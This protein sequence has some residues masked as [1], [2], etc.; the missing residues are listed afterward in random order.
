MDLNHLTTISDIA[1]TVRTTLGPKGMNKFVVGN[2]PIMTND[3]A[4]IIKHLKHPHPLF[5]PIKNLANSQEETVGDGTTTTMILLAE[6]LRGAKTLIEKGMHPVTVIEGYNLC[7]HALIQYLM[8][9]SEELDL[10][11]V[12]MTTFGSKI[13]PELAKH[14]APMIEPDMDIFNLKGDPLNSEVVSGFM[15][16]GHTINDQMPSKAAGKIAVLNLRTMIDGVKVQASTADELT[17]L[18]HKAHEDRLNVVQALQEYKVEVLVTNDSDET[19]NS[20]LAQAGIMTIWTGD[21]SKLVK[22]CKVTGAQIT[23]FPEERYLGECT[24]TYSKKPNFIR[25]TGQESEVK[26]LLLYG[27]TEQTL[28]ETKLAVEDVIG[29]IKSS[30]GQ[31]YGGGAIEMELS[32][33]LRANVNTVNGK[34]QIAVEKFAE[35]LES[36]PMTLAHNCGFDQI[37]ILTKLRTLHAKGERTIGVDPVSQIS[38]A[39]QRKLVEPVNVKINA[40]NNATELANLV[41]KMDDIYQGEEDGND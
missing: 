36:I 20:L 37:D 17:K 22:I 24:C 3:G 27:A 26:T 5:G 34:E 10:E 38:C 14:L 9:N 12:I 39:K 30:T 21:M 16:K 31:V 7:R 19:F 33:M 2:M 28:E 32:K 11:Q 40:I 1:D 8:N 29:V 25:I 13:S 18:E 4:T 23:M 6:L 35:A 15:M 41:L